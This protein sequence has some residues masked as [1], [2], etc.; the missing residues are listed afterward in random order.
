MYMCQECG[1]RF[2]STNAAERAASRGCP[3]C[4]G[5][6]IDLASP[7]EPLRNVEKFEREFLNYVEQSYES[8][9]VMIEI[10]KPRDAV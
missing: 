7:R 1:K 2:R 4:G 8:D 5:V 6:D 10:R 9:D 3:K